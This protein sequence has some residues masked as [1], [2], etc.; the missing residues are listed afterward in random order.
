M[1]SP[2]LLLLDFQEGVC[3][4]DG[5]IGSQ[6]TG[7]EVTRRGALDRARAALEEFRSREWPVIHVRVAFDPDYHRMTSSSRR[8]GAMRAH[9]LLQADDPWSRICPEVAPKDGEPVV[10]KGCVS[11]FVG[12]H[13]PQLLTRLGPGE[14]VLA[15]VAT[16]HVVEST[17]RHAA[18][19]GHPVVVLEDACASF[20]EAMHEFSVKRILP[21]YARVSTVSAVLSEGSKG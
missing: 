21:A 17:A 12:T 8:F 4:E 3:R 5:P 10:D 1:A 9:R 14:L 2:L 11:P 6:G 18:D 20:D 19:T 16:N 7:A 13:L 15:G